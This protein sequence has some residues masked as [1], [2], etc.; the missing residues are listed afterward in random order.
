MENGAS[1]ARERERERRV[2]KTRRYRRR[3]EFFVFFLRAK[4]F[5]FFTFSNREKQ[6]VLSQKADSFFLLP[7]TRWLRAP[8]IRKPRDVRLLASKKGHGEEKKEFTR[9]FFFSPFGLFGFFPDAAPRRRQC[10]P[11][12]ARLEAASRTSST[13][14]AAERARPRGKQQQQQA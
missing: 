8:D 3:V 11:A 5:S 12:A 7:S 4:F 14:C 13:S 2:M 1:R 6:T 9:S 10:C